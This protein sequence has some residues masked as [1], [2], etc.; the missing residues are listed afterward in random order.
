[1]ADSAT[2][3]LSVEYN[4]L[5]PNCG[6][7]V[8][9][10]C[11]GGGSFGQWIPTYNVP[12]QPEETECHKI[13]ERFYELG[14]NF[15]D[16][17]VGYTMGQSEKFI[18]SWM[19]GKE[20]SEV[21][22]ATKVGMPGGSTLNKSSLSRVSIMSN[23]EL[24]LSRLQT[25]YVDLLYSHVWDAGTKLEET[26]RAFNDLV[27]CGKVRYLGVSNV[28]GP[29]LQK[30]ACYCK[31]M[32]LDPCL[33]VQQEYNLLERQADL[34][35]LPICA[36]EGIGFQ[37]YSALKGG[38]LTGKFK[39]EDRDV[40]QSLRGTRLAWVN[41]KPQERAL[42]GSAPDV[43]EYRNNENYWK[44]MEGVETIAKQH[45]KTLTQVSLRWLLQKKFV[46]SCLI[47][48]KNLAQ[49]DE[50]MGAG[51][52]WTLTDDQMNQLDELSKFWAP[53]RVYPYAYIDLTN[54]GRRRP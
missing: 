1:M 21:I 22:V 14:G 45:G 18:G 36:E 41:E 50:C 28:T 37:P 48:V 33:I 25:D 2:N 43:D 10:L 9:N 6:L 29:Q 27:R 23:I 11:L 8:S 54:I 30:I 46:S 34:D 35:I 42:S 47:A 16:T 7:K 52:G 17:A 24:S 20:R 4:W 39:R 38:L 12:S 3:S 51:T 26:L 15:I 5:G 44:L 31:F 13:L 32:G 19:S 49:L 53:A 40:Q